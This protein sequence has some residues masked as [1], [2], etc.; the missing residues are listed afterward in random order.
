MTE[1]IGMNVKH[2]EA[3]VK[4]TEDPTREEEDIMDAVEGALMK[5][6]TKKT[7]TTAILETKME[8]GQMTSMKMIAEEVVA[9]VEGDISIEGMKTAPEEET[10]QGR[11]KIKT[12][13]TEAAMTTEGREISS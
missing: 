13:I 12:S 4:M 3:A 5:I 1:T 8:A 10:T 11:M 7:E 9:T 6:N 2:L